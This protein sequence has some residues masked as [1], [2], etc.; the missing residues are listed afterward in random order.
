MFH[1]AMFYNICSLYDHAVTFY[2][3][4]ILDV[5]RVTV[6]LTGLNKE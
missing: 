2:T 6:R 4:D 5:S 1:L 3:Y